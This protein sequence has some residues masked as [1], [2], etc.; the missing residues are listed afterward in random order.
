MTAGDLIEQAAGLAASCRP[1]AILL[2]SGLQLSDVA[3][4]R[5]A[6]Q[7]CG[8]RLLKTRTQEGWALLAMRRLTITPGDGRNPG[9]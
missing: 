8:C 7:A 4:V 1:G 9:L 6:Y 2:L 3:E 5:E